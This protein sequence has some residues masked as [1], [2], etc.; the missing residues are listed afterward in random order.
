MKK[1]EAWKLLIEYLNN[2]K[3]IVHIDFI[4]DVKR[5]LKKMKGQEK[6]FFNLLRKQLE[7]IL[8]LSEYNVSKANGNELLKHCTEFDCYS[9]HLCS[10]AFNIR[11]LGTYYKQ[12]FIFLLAFYEMSGKKNT[13]YKKYI[14]IAIKRLNEIKE[15]IIYE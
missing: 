3:F 13:E 1:E 8:T 15:E 12:K 2:E 4:E 9:L 14:S 7:Y 6:K 11:L 5:L 10:T